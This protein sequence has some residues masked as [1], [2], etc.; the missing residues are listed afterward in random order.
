LLDIQDL[1]AAELEHP[2][3]CILYLNLLIKLLHAFHAANNPPHEGEQEEQITNQNKGSEQPNERIEE[4]NPEG[5]D[6]IAK[7]AD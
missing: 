7:M 2:A 1:E 4:T 3:A 5:A 6:L